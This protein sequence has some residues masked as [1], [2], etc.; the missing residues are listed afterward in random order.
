M[1]SRYAILMILEIIATIVLK[2]ISIP[3]TVIAAV[4][5]VIILFVH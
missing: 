2:N 4:V 3:A 1:T 5:I